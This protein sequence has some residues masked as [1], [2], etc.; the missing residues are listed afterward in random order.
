MSETDTERALKVVEKLMKVAP[1]GSVNRFATRLHDRLI[2]R[3]NAVPMTQVIEKIPGASIVAKA[4]ACGVSR[5]AI[6]YWLN[7]ETRP[8][9]K[10]AKTLQRLTGFAADEIRGVSDA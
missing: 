7:G 3:L 9:E 8:N 2:K 10:Q 1:R 5:Q 6:Y 4:R